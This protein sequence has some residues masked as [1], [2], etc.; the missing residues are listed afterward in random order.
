LNVT[1]VIPVRAGSL[2]LKDKNISK[3]AGTNLLIN[4]IKQLKA[5]PSINKI[6]VS[7]D[8]EIMLGMAEEAN[9]FTQKRPAE[10]CDEITK[11]FSDVIEWVCSD[12]EGDHILWATC[13][14]PLTDENIYQAALEKYF[15]VLGKYDSL[16]TFEKFQHFLWDE[17]GPVNYSAGSQFGGSKELKPL[18]KKTCGISIAPRND[19]IK[20][21]FDHGTN[22]YM[23]IIDKRSAVDIDDIYDLVC[24]RAWLDI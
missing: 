5:V 20:W 3:F 2:R 19:I 7:S 10:Y 11:S 16:V 23:Y 15:E 4:K 17:N 22:P 21:K 14:S 12:L 8:S 6:V 13:T 1:A 24:A 18:Y 9:V